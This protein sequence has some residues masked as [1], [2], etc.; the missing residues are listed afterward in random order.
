[1]II[2]HKGEYV[3]EFEMIAPFGPTIYSAKLN[4]K[5]LKFVKHFAELN[6][7]AD[8]MGYALSG[9]IEVQRGNTAAS[10]EMQLQ[11]LGLLVPHVQEWFKADDERR[12][13]MMPAHEDGA[14]EGLAVNDVDYNSIQFDLGN[15][16]WFNYMKANEFNPAHAHS[17][18]ISGII[19]VD[20]PE[21]IANEPETI[22]IESNARCPGQLEWVH[23]S[24]GA[25]AHRIV[26]VTGQIFMFPAELKHQVYPFKSD[27]E[28]LTMSWNVFNV[29]F[30]KKVEIDFG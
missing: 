3:S 2:N 30:D 20:V 25:S 19:M 9:N 14:I 15:G 6:R 24:W 29:T 17:D 7:N 16:V 4:E 23:G 8:H 28:R 11:M 12:L 21:E 27:V 18:M 13:S 22:P 26:P 1:M 5:D 10:P